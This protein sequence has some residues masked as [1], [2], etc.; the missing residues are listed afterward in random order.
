M[1]M[2]DI[3][4][5]SD[6][7]VAREVGGETVI[8]HLGSGTYFSLNEVGGRIWQLLE[9]G[10]RPVAELCAVI[11]KEFDAPREVIEVD[12]LAL[13][14]DLMDKDLVTRRAA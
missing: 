10:D 7:A 6:D 5:V 2:D 12:V 1:E 14:T 3:L 8:M 4:S 13:A 9:A 11:V